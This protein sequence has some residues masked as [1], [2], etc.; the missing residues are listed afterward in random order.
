MSE[1]QLSIIYHHRTMGDGAE[2]IHVS[3]IVAALRGLGHRVKLVCPKSAK[4]SPGLRSQ[5]TR[6]VQASP[7]LPKVLRQS[8][9]IA[10][11]M[12]CYAR[13]C[14]AIAQTKPDLI[15][16]RYSSYN[17]GGVMAAKH[18]RVPL[19]LEVN[20]TYA[21]DFGS[22]FPVV[23]PA[24]LAMAEKY[25]LRNASGIVV[26]SSALRACVEKRGV[27]RDLI[28]VS[29]NAINPEKIASLVNI[30]SR[31]EM[32]RELRMENAVVIGFVGSL[33]EWHGID[34]LAQA[35]PTIVAQCPSTK[36]LIVGSGNLESLLVDLIHEHRLSDR[37][38]LTG[39]L[40]HEQV[41]AHISAMDIGLMPD[42]N[43]WGS[44][45]KVLEYMALGCV[46]VVPDLGPLK[47]IVV[48]D[49]TGKLFP[50]RDLPQF[51]N[52]IVQL[53][54]DAPL[55]KRLGDSAQRY[56]YEHRKW[57]NNACQIIDL[58]RSVTSV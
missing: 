10:Y 18:L 5:P 27:K 15:Y 16:E 20:S 3:E 47:E 34:L 50:C 38:I 55:R 46:P 6:L 23:F 31:S 53:A 49:V 41:F 24:A 45:M 56:V 58:F 4:S 11:N 51:V 8:L 48:N 40:P 32:R 33:R 22:E 43:L 17:F 7:K 1:S 30:H 14:R 52:T 26:V 12:V 42:S 19:I 9:E 57:Q 2:G 21:G 36:F 37:V 35:I 39:A 29:P 25:S 13:V 44:P 28:Q 54:N